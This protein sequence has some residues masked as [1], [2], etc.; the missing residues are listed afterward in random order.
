[1]SLFL[2]TA[3]PRL[4]KHP[5]FAGIEWASEVLWGWGGAA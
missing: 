5:G 2:R 1:M 3:Q 4:H